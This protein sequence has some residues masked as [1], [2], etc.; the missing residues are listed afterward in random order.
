MLA[1]VSIFGWRYFNKP[2]EVSLSASS[3]HIEKSK[4]IS[5]GKGYH[6]RSKV[7][8][9][10]EAEIKEEYAGTTEPYREANIDAQ[11]SGRIK[12]I[13][14][15]EGEFVRQGDVLFTLYDDDRTNKLMAA[16]SEVAL[17]K[18]Q[19]VAAQKLE[20]KKFTS[21]ISLANAYNNLQSANLGLRK[22]EL[23]HARL[24][25]KAPFDGI[26]NKVFVE[27][28]TIL[29]DSMI[30]LNLCRIVTLSPLYVTIEVPERAYEQLKSLKTVYVRLTDNREVEGTLVFVSSV[31]N[32]KT[33]TFKAKIQIDNSDLVLPAGMSVSVV[34]PLSFSNIHEL[35]P[36]IITLSREGAAGV[37]AIVSGKAQ[38]MP[39][40]IVRATK[41]AFFVTGLPTRL[42]VIT[43]GQN[44]IQDG[45]DVRYDDTST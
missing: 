33:K 38:F 28:N 12:K 5:P 34:L 6:V 20:A 43:L 39:V 19:Y 30:G 24:N 44:A 29:S 27:P 14:V 25:V 40:K 11:I 22:A 35:A 31:A 15:R 16:R 2:Q 37:M 13:H 26:V 9:A 10:R 32:E 4:P 17:R 42:R 8:V 23:N 1:L 21:P 18:M 3:D 45:T 7:S 36:S 41:Q